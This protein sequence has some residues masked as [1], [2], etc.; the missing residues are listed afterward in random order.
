[1]G[2]C[3]LLVLLGGMFSGLTLGLLSLDPTTLHVLSVGGKPD[4]QK[5]AKRIAPLVKRHHLLLV[6]LLL[7]NATAMEALPLFLDNLVPEVIAIVISVSAVLLF[8]EC[9]SG[10]SLLG[11]VL[12]S[13]RVAWLLFS[14]IL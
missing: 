14:F 3:I 7:S 6:T 9:V 12:K 4:Q 5:Y 2:I 13:S 10:F 8:G 11:R 1:M